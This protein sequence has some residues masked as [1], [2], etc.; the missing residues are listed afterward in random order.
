MSAV[1]VG[2]D[3]SKDRLDVWVVPTSDK[4]NVPNEVDGLAELACRISEVE[5][6]LVVMEATGGF[7]RPVRA[8]LEEAGFRCAVVNPRHVRDFA[9]SMGIKAKTDSLDAFVLATFGAKMEPEA[10]PGK[11]RDTLE[12]EAVL[13]RRRQLVGIAAAE[14]N[15]LKQA[16][17]EQVRTDIR[18]HIAWIET[19]LKD[20]DT[21]IRTRI[22]DMPQSR[23]K[24]KIIRSVPGIGRITT[25]TLLAML[26]ELGK[27]TRKEIASLAGL[28]PFNRDSGKFQGQRCIWGGRAAVRSVLYMSALSAIR[29]NS[30]IK[31]FYNRLIGAGK[32]KKVAI[33]ACMRK[34]LI[35][36]NS[37][38]RNN[39]M[40][41]PRA[42]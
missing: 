2:I 28:A 13:T 21:D 37:M 22:K 32:K 33:T 40:W 25:P 8:V 41:Q 34:L 27:L 16:P 11:D 7:E 12:L 23:E 26:P 14:K 9:K 20:L 24:A 5:P 36:L 30:A 6:K 4:W 15:R 39:T 18:D 31:A 10:R 38:V 35:I 29:W 19:R 1:V 42:A 17:S 3:I